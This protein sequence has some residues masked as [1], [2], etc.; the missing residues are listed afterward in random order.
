M[1]RNRLGTELAVVALVAAAALGFG[2]QWAGV[3]SGY[4]D[5]L[6]RAGAQDE[7]VYG[8]A[9]A[10]MVH[11]GHWLTPIF[12][13]RFMLNKPPLLMW[14]GALAMRLFGVNPVALR[15]PTIAAGMLCCLLV[16][17][18]LRLSRPA[19][20]AWSGVLLLL[21]NALFHSMTRKFMTDAVL[22]LLVTSAMFTVALDPGFERAVTAIGFGALSGA[23]IL[24]KSAAGFVPLLI[25]MLYF[26]L[27]RAEVRPAVNRIVLA[28]SV[29]VLVAAPWHLY[30]WLV[31]RDWFVAEY[32]RFQLLG[33]GISAPSRYTGQTNLSF[34]AQRLIVLDPLLLL[35]WCVA[36]GWVAVAWKR[37]SEEYQTRLL[38]AWCVGSFVCLLVFGTRVAYYLLPLVPAM[39]LM[40]VQFSPLFRGRWAAVLCGLLAIAFG[41]KAW[42]SDATWGIEYQ[43]ES[44]P[45]AAALERYGQLRRAN[46]LLIVSPDDEFYS[47]VL[48]LAKPRYVYLGTLD[49]TKT[50]DFFN[51]LGVN[52]S[53]PDFCNLPALL[54]VYRQHLAAW[55][56]PDTK[57]VGTI[58]SGSA[59]TD[60]SSLIRCSPERDFF[61]PDGLRDEALESAKVTHIAT[62]SENGRFFLL[63]RNSQRRPENSHRPGAILAAEARSIKDSVVARILPR[64]PPFRAPW[65]RSSSWSPLYPDR[66][67]P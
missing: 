17:W 57:P 37:P 59:G 7:A 34:Y 18:W 45:S 48:D 32:V 54:P 19:V 50:S 22:M 28:I 63:A 51:W 47:S 67:S 8:H 42:R 13:D 21:G 29:A 58:I 64:S 1:A 24:T 12:L 4:V 52:V 2:I 27:L 43:P 36:V 10:R 26:F 46:D 39:V 35:L 3:A 15:L 6:L 49:P 38:T 61:L 25:L 60:V 14:T 5:P 66:S 40:S 20:V 56:F 55:R 65:G 62:E 9:A 30:Q 33:S 23:A 31:H 44:V 41:V 11:T 16:Y 53:A